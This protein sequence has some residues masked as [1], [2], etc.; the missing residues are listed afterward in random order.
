ME[1]RKGASPAAAN[2]G[3]GRSSP[4]LAKLTRP[5]ASNAVL[6]HRLFTRLDEA[7]E[8]PIVWIHGPPGAGKTTLLASYLSAKKRAGIWY[9]IDSDDSD[10]ASFFYYLGLAAVANAPRKRRPM[11][12]LT[13]ANLGPDKPVSNNGAEKAK[14]KN[15][16]EAD[17]SHW[18][19]GALDAGYFDR[20]ATKLVMDQAETSLAK[21]PGI[22]LA[23][24]QC[25]ERFCRATLI[26]EKSKPLNIGQL[27]GASPFMGSGTTIHEPDGSV[28]VYF[29]PPGQSISELRSEA[30]EVALGDIH[31]E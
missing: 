11:P 10:P 15:F 5:Q 9:Q 17:F 7:Q 21:V 19:D 28:K 12:L 22:N 3:G 18:M 8:R 23:D 27:V 13:Q 16:S 26:P 29:T 24:L 4:K 14:A 2:S 30:Q 20:D 6:R 31:T 1:T 25:S